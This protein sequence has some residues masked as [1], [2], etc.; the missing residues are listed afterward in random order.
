MV[1][2][3]YALLKV[4]HVAF[5]AMWLGGGAFNVFVLQRQ[6]AQA[7]VIVRRE[8]GGRYFAA[9]GPYFNIVGLLTILTGLGLVYLHPLG[10]GGLTTSLWG[11]LIVFGLVASLLVLYLV[12]FAIRPTFKAIAKIQASLEPDALMPV[13][14]RFLLLRVRVT[15]VLNVVILFGVAAAMVGANVS[16]FGP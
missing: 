16:V 6:L 2:A 1:N 4:L 12:N 13:N 11:R 10:T 9:L 3:G 7:T 8:F 14:L 5:A 15:S